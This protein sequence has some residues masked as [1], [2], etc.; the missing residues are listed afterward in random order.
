MYIY[1]NTF[2][3]ISYKCEILNLMILI[4][5]IYECASIHYHVP[6]LSDKIASSINRTNLPQMA[7]L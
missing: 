6:C 4:Y 7:L 5:A 2:I 1:I 3:L